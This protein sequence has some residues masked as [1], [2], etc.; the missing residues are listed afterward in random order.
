MVLSPVTVFN[1]VP[2]ARIE[3]AQD[4]SRGILSPLRLPVPPFGQ[5]DKMCYFSVCVILRVAILCL[6]TP[7]IHF[8]LL[9]IVRFI[10]VFF[11]NCNPE[12]QAVF[13][14]EELF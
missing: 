7:L 8:F 6:V 13:E 10:T 11:F 1:M 3:L 2:E 5:Y 4:Y 14:E 9:Y 12:L